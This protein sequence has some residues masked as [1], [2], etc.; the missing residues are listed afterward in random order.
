MKRL[1]AIA[2]SLLIAGA[3]LAVSQSVEEKAVL[4]VVDRMFEGMR[5]ADSAMVRSTFANGARFAMLDTR[6]TPP[7]ITYDSI[8][9][10]LRGIAGSN[11]RWDEQVYDM[12]ARVDA[13]IAQ[14]WAPYTFY[15]DKKVRHCGVDIFHFLKLNGEWKVTQLSDSRRTEGCPD[16]LGK[17]GGG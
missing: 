9:G 4:A 16:P 3:D 2:S 6:S 13:D 7:R 12:Q 1:L 10:W 17:R 11:R 5:T 15:L 14:V 8:N